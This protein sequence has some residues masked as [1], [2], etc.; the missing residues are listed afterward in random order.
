MGWILKNSAVVFFP[1]YSS[2]FLTFI[3]TFL[4]STDSGHNRC[5]RGCGGR[6]VGRRTFELFGLQ[7]C[8]NLQTLQSF[9]GEVSL[10]DRCLFVTVVQPKGYVPV[11]GGPGST[12]VHQV[13]FVS[14][15]GI[16][17]ILWV[18]FLS[19]RFK[20]IKLLKDKD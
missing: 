14:V 6:V 3:L 7:L 19:K 2:N 5:G 4:Y 9:S 1:P 12:Q 15:R 17:L 13:Q 8:V 10:Q 20:V 11:S 18:Y 16:S